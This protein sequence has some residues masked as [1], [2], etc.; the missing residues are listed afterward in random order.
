MRLFFV[1]FAALRL[2]WKIKNKQTNKLIGSLIHWFCT[3]QLSNSFWETL[4]SLCCTPAP[5]HHPLHPSNNPVYITL[6]C[7]R[8]STASGFMVCVHCCCSLSLICREPS[9]IE[10]LRWSQLDCCRCQSW[11][12]HN[13]DRYSG[14]TAKSK[15]LEKR[16]SS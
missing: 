8:R 11:K 9:R 15:D 13:P 5:T 2:P 7:P 3:W 14:V 12:L 16:T 4:L 1:F 10:P 6:F